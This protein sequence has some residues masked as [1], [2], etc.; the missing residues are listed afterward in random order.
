MDREHKRNQAILVTMA[1]EDPN[2][3]LQKA[4]AA[5]MASEDLVDIGYLITIARRAPGYDPDRD[6]F[7][8]NN[9][10]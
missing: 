2:V 3:F 9:I 1:R 7:L 6:P 8:T 5:G 4:Y 10:G